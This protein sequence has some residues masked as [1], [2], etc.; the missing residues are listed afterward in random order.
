MWKQ[1]SDP[2]GTE[3]QGLDSSRPRPLRSGQVDVRQMSEHEDLV[4]LDYGVMHQ[5]YCPRY[6]S[7]TGLRLEYP[8]AHPKREQ[9]AP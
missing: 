5:T 3:K 8:C 6:Y 7:L 4:G 2:G 9:L 1:K